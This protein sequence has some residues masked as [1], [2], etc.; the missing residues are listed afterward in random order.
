MNAL[1]T[2]D[3]VLPQLAVVA[4]SGLMRDIIAEHFGAAGEGYVARQAKQC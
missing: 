2:P 4:D 1:L 3:P